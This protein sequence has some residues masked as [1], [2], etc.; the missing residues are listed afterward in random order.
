MKQKNL[1][2]RRKGLSS[3][4]ELCAEAGA[5]VKLSGI[6]ELWEKGELT[7]LILTAECDGTTSASPQ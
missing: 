5:I 1:K 2:R 3:S 4:G 6:C 7:D